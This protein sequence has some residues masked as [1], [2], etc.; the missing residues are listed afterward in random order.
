MGIDYFKTP[1]SRGRFM[2]WPPD[3][4]ELTKTGYYANEE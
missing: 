3:G 1:V 2:C 4:S